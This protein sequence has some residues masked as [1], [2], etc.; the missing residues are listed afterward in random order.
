MYDLNPPIMKAQFNLINKPNQSIKLIV[1]LFD[2]SSKKKDLIE[3]TYNKSTVF[4]YTLNI[5]NSHYESNIYPENT[6]VNHFNKTIIGSFVYDI[7]IKFSV[8]Q[9][10]INSDKVSDLETLVYGFLKKDFTYSVYKKNSNKSNYKTSF[11]LHKNLL[12]QLNSINFL[13]ELVT[14]P[15]NIIFPISFAKRTQTQINKKNVSFLKLDKNKIKK[16]GLNCLLAV[17]QGSKRDPMVM[18]FKKK[19]TKKNVDILFVGKGVCFD[20][21]GISIKPSGGMEDI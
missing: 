2:K 7:S 11:K 6:N 12:S 13:K 16:I 19:N 9:I 18:E 10:I 4:K 17:S 21:G 5:K 15:S 14:E 1:N 8:S 20:S 3:H